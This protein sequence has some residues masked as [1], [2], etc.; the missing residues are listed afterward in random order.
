MASSNKSANGRRPARCDSRR[1]AAGA[2]GTVAASQ[3]VIGIVLRPAK[4]A[5]VQA[6]G[7]RP[8]PLS[9]ST[10]APS[11]GIA[12][13]A[14]RSPPTPLLTGSTTVNVMAAANAASTALPPRCSAASPACAASGCEVVTI[15]RPATERRGAVI[16]NRS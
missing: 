9:A 14:N 15:A 3:P 2:P 11:P 12:T 10:G 1:Q 4:R 13:R 7:A 6:I 8:L 5:G 16:V